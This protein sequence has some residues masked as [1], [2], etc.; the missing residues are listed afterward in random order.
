MKPLSLYE[1]LSFE[2][3]TRII[4]FNFHERRDLFTEFMW[5]LLCAEA[6]IDVIPRKWY[7]DYRQHLTDNKN[8][9]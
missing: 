8:S 2:D 6:P 5:D 9:K 3:A 7:D 1:K 4:F